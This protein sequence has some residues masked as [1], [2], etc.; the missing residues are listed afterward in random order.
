MDSPK[1]PTPFAAPALDSASN[2]SSS[3]SSDSL[4]EAADRAFADAYE[5]KQE[6]ESDSKCFLVDQKHLQLTVDYPPFLHDL[7]DLIHQPTFKPKL[8]FFKFKPDYHG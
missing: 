6:L 8:A 5:I 1:E 7:C 2:S 4:S 3:S